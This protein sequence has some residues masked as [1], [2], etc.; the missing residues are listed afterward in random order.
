MGY[1]PL[2]IAYCHR[3]AYCHSVAHRLGFLI[4]YFLNLLRT[5]AARAWRRRSIWLHVDADNKRA[6]SLYLANGYAAVGQTGWPWRQQVL[7]CKNLPLSETQRALPSVRS[8]EQ[9]VFLWDIK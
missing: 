6:Q 9:G 7:M 5:A 2:M 1:E 4:I 8:G 3:V